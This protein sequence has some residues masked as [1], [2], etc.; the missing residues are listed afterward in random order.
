VTLAASFLVVGPA[1]AWESMQ[2][3]SGTPI[4][5]PSG[6]PNTV[7]RLSSSLPS[8]DLSNS[9]V[10]S[11]INAAFAEWGRPGCSAFNASQSSD[12]VG[13]P[14]D[15][16]NSNNIIGFY[17]NGWPS[18]YGTT[19]L[20][21]T[22]TGW[23]EP[24]C[25]ITTADMVVNGTSHYWVVGNPD[26]WNEADL[27]AVMAHETGHWIG[28]DHSNYSGS[29]LQAMYT[30]GIG[31]RT[32]TC[33]DTDG[34]CT[35]YPS[36]G[37]SCTHDRYCECSV[38]CNGGYCGGVPSGDDDDDDDDDDAT[39]G[40]DDDDATD[41]PQDDDDSDV[42]G[43]C[44]GSLESYDESE[45]NDWQDEEDVDWFESNGGDLVIEGSLTCGNNGSQYTADSDWFVIDIPCT[46]SGRFA[47]DWSGSNSDLDFYIWGA[48]SEPVIQSAT[49]EFE[50]PVFDDG[51]GSGRLFVQLLCWEGN[52]TD[53]SFSIDWAPFSASGDDDDATGS[54]GDDD[55][56]GSSDDDD[57]TGSSGDD[58][59]D[60]DDDDGVGTT[61]LGDLGDGSMGSSDA[62]CSCRRS[63][64][65]SSSASPGAFALAFLLVVFGGWRR[66]DAFLAP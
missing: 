17:E 54:P 46:D 66:S 26:N 25:D 18:N 21:V 53:Y 8:N 4:A 55:T 31:E 47:L 22:L 24:G 52:P 43:D 19:T 32:I 20:A 13:D 7:W 2:T 44:S 64:E 34:A 28:F 10:D 30:G 60:D 14:T 50:G 38:G 36:S 33:D 15:N 45:P 1:F 35:L 9:E 48:D 12:A 58:D 39:S 11:A 23:T 27:Q 37:N 40:Q 6:N 41:P 42:S 3:C 57:A 29:T 51:D 63:W 56:G 65:A 16:N 49:A 5:W 62:G 59:D 61:T